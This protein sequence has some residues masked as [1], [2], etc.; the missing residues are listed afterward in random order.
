MMKRYWAARVLVYGLL[1]FAGMTAVCRP[2]YALDLYAADYSGNMFLIETSPWTVTSAGV[3]QS[4]PSTTLVREMAMDYGPD[5]ELYA[6]TTRSQTGTLNRRYH[7]GE[8]YMVDPST[9]GDNTVGDAVEPSGT[10]N[11]GSFGFVSGAGQPNYDA[12]LA[13]RDDGKF[14]I[15]GFRG[16][17]DQGNRIYLNDFDATTPAEIFTTSSYDTRRGL[18]WYDDGS[19]NGMLFSLS[20]GLQLQLINLNYATHGFSSSFYATVPN[21]TG[22]TFGDLAVY[23]DTLFVLLSGTAGSRILS[24]DLSQGSGGSFMSTG[25]LTQANLKSL[26]APPSTAVTPEPAS[27]MLLGLG[28]AGAGLRRFRRKK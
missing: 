19:E 8:I 3:I 11:F 2:G 9:V 18:E 4:N 22:M 5:G 10:E 14:F 15:S 12:G 17:P 28:L 26:A 21:T 20:G 27:M 7:Y 16:S 1:F 23:E 13:F 25:D 24:Y 6:Y